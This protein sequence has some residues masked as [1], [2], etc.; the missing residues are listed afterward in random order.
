MAEFVGGPLMILILALLLRLFLRSRT[1]DPR[2]SRP[3]AASRAGW[4]ATPE[5]T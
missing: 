3:T 1:L 5:W 2:G 4:R